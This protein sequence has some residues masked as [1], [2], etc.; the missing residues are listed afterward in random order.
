MRVI[1][2]SP[3]TFGATGLFGGGERYPYELA[4]ALSTDVDCKLLTFGSSPQAFRHGELE[5]VVLERRLML[6]GHPAQPIARGVV[7]ELRHADVIHA[8]HLRALPSRVGA[9]AAWARGQH[10]VVTDHGLGR[11]RGPHVLT[12]LFERFLTVSRYSSETLR[13]PTEKTDVVYGGADTERFRPGPGDER[14]GVLFVGRLT[15]HKGVDR[16]IEAL[17]TGA[18]LTV[19]GTAGHDP[20]APERDYPA[21]LARLAQGRDV[22]FAG[23][24]SED[25][26]PVLYRRARVFV[27]PSVEVTCY[28]RRIAIPELLGLSLLEAMASGTPVIATRVGGLPEVVVD[29][30]TGFVVEPGDEAALRA[31]LEELL[32]NARLAAEMGSN[33]RQHVV[34]RF[35]WDRCAER[36]LAAYSGVMGAA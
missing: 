34:D 21:L 2:I 15:P 28:G 33:A 32:G 24:V 23:V 16:L 3:T 31:R 11:G 27:L 26:L 20:G 6:G 35:T 12:H 10:R 17:P 18:K 22:R 1:H 13:A 7:A 8:H 29:G 14:E 25:Q 30:E 9:L 4:R 36:C 19:A 5:V